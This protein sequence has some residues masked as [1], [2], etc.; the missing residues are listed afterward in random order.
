M[1]CNSCHVFNFMSEQTCLTITR[2][3]I[4]AGALETILKFSPH[5]NILARY[6]HKSPSPRTI[7]SAFSSLSGRAH[8]SA[9]ERLENVGKDFSWNPTKFKYPFRNHKDHITYDKAYCIAYFT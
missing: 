1:H 7:S 6:M 2:V 9:R 4:D 8:K 3:C 5:S